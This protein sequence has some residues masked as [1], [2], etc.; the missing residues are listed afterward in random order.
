MARAKPQD[1]GWIP[2]DTFAGRLVLTRR[3]LGR[4]SQEEAAL[5]CGVNPKTW[6]QWELGRHPQEMHLVIDQIHRALG[7]DRN[8][9]MWGVTLR[10]PAAL[11][12][13]ALPDEQ[14]ELFL[15]ATAIHRPLAAA[16]G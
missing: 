10:Q 11:R 4:I 13:V 1:T 8:W 2:A 6:A 7:V 14:L 5:R 12:V 9:L 16:D 3:H 15:P